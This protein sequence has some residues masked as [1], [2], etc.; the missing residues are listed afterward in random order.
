[1]SPLV[2]WCYRVFCGW[3]L[4]V[5]LCSRSFPPPVEGAPR[6]VQGTTWILLECVASTTP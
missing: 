2:K 6:S 3:W 1:M 5:C 4:Q